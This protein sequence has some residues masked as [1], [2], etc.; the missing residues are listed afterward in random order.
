M[1]HFHEI[2]LCDILMVD[3]YVMFHTLVYAYPMHSMPKFDMCTAAAFCWSIM[4][5]CSSQWGYMMHCQNMSVTFWVATYSD[6]MIAPCE[7]FTLSLFTATCSTTIGCHANVQD[8]KTRSERGNIIVKGHPP[9]SLTGTQIWWQFHEATC[10]LDS[11]SFES[12]YF[13]RWSGM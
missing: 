7:W 3:W 5:L 10:F 12:I 11:C 2:L 13:G 4:S 8:T 9:I 1:M 6:A